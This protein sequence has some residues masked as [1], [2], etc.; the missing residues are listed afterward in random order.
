[1]T[2]GLAFT[3]MDVGAMI[4]NRGRNRTIRIWGEEDPVFIMSTYDVYHE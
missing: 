3:A 4:M 2:F 1:M